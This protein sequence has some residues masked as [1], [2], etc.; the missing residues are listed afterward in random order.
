MVAI[1]NGLFLGGVVVALGIMFAARAVAPWFR[2]LA[3]IP[4]VGSLPWPP[5]AVG[6]G[7]D[8]AAEIWVGDR[9]VV[10][11][12]ARRRDSL[13]GS[14]IVVNVDRERR[15]LS[16]RFFPVDAVMLLVATVP[17]ALLHPRAFLPLWLKLILV[18][19]G[20][21]FALTLSV[22]QARTNVARLARRLK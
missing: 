7:D 14:I 6:D 16:A 1:A 19:A 9:C 2:G 15:Q 11:G 10:L 13:F 3:R 21:I 8:V 12:A 18:A 5:S 4:L 17:A 22:S 20:A